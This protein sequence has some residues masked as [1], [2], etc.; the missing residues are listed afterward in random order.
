MPTLGPGGTSPEIPTVGPV[1]IPGYEILGELGRGGM[2][3]VYKARQARPRRL[4]ALKVVLAGEH[5]GTDAMARFKTEAAA[6]ARLSHPNIVQV[7]EVG[8]HRGRPFLTLELVEGGNLAQKLSEG[9]L[10]FRE[11]AGLLYQL[12]QA[13]H[14]AHQKG[15]IHRDLKP[16]NILLA[17]D[18]ENGPDALGVPKIADFGL[19]K[20]IEGMASVAVTGPRTQS[21]AILGTPSYMAPEQAGG[22]RDAAGPAADVYALGAILYECLTGRPPFQADTMLDTLMQVATQEPVPP[23]KLRPK[24]PRD[25]ETICLKCLEKDPKR[26]YATAGALADDLRRYREDR[27]I[28]CRPPG[29]LERLG[30]AL[31]KRKELVYPAAGALAALCVSLVVLAL[32][33]PG[34]NE[35]PVA[36]R[37]EGPAYELPADLDLVPR[38]A[39]AF[40][41][42]RVADLW[43]RQDLQNLAAMLN[44]QQAAGGRPASEELARLQRDTGIAPQDIER[45]TLV[46][47]KQQDPSGSVFLLALTRPYDRERVYDAVTQRGSPMH[48]PETVGGKKVYFPVQE[49][50]TAFCPFSDRVL[51]VGS[52]KPLRFLLERD[53]KANAPAAGGPLR[54]ALML[55]A[56]SHPLVVGVH[57][58]REIFESALKDLLLQKQQESLAEMEA[59]SLVLDLTAPAE[60]E[61]VH[62][63]PGFSVDLDLTFPD[64]ARARQ[65]EAAVRNLLQD[66]LRQLK[67]AELPPPLR[68]WTDSLLEPVRAAR[69]RQEGNQV[70][71][72]LT[73]RWKPRDLEQMQAAA[74]EMADR[75]QSLNNLRQIALALHNYHSATG[76]FPPA[77]VCGKDDK[78]LY[79]W[80][81]EIL[82]YLDED[83]LYKEFNRDEPWDSEHNRKLLARMPAVYALP[84]PRK[85]MG[86][87]ERTYYQALVGPGAAF[88]GRQGLRIADFTKGTSNTLMVVEAARPVPWSSP[89]DLPYDPAKPVPALGGHFKDGFNAAFASGDARFLSSP[90]PEDMLRGYIVRGGTD[91]VQVGPDAVRLNDEAWR[92]ATGPADKR[93]PA[94]A[95]RLIQQAVANEPNNAMFLNTLGVV[96]YRN[97]LYKEAVATLEKSLASGEGKWDGFDLFFLAMCHAKLGD[98]VKAK[99]CFDRAVQWRDKQK[100]LAPQHAEEL[101]AF[102]AEAEAALQAK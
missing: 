86:L 42:M 15:V 61:G 14:F 81:V 23:R 51:L 36:G 30:R 64:E 5:A 89:E 20:Q 6:V 21:G 16:A 37:A 53:T 98:P 27:P 59:A 68:G 101:K 69:W 35:V 2:G 58:P 54:G 79:S 77:V 88:E 57:P 95:L 8:D 41:T 74:R 100:A 22:K 73:F 47:P 10:R 83:R 102:R 80:R 45:L 40:A 28:I 99:D 34:K 26:R 38:D 48:P 24:C 92:L 17:P 66:V 55:A 11:T 13:V 49:W 1:S 25:L 12:A 32:W 62:T 63:L 31:R 97:E 56:E 96:Q 87:N 94:R 75:N 72:A 70:R 52:A 50:G 93:D 85:E 4:V 67:P 46:V 43:A 71:L 19:A 44:P 65:G 90:L 39:F 29:R 33:S 91:P 18:D 7:H 76:H 82:P 60:G 3:V 9:P 84:R 78:P